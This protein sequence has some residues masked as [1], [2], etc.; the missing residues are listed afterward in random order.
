MSIV[1]R[2]QVGGLLASMTSILHCEAKD[3]LWLA[4]SGHWDLNSAPIEEPD[5]SNFNLTGR[6]FIQ[7][8]V[9]VKDEQGNHWHRFCAGRAF[10][11]C[12]GNSSS[13]M[14]LYLHP[15]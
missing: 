11:V 8:T 1:E 15:P 2:S 10:G 14:Q 6:S 3:I 9:R 12:G 13:C 7:G 5:I 4:N